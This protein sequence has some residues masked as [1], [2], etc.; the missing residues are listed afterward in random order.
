MSFIDKPIQL[1]NSFAK[2]H[3]PAHKFKF[4]VRCNESKPPEGGIEL[5]RE[6]WYCAK[7][8]TL[9]MTAPKKGKA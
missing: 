3:Q 1:P 2:Q 6:R 9:K 4:C 8:W 7:C 5:S